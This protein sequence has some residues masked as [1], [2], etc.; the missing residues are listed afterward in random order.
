MQ[1]AARNLL[2]VQ[3]DEDVL[4]HGFSDQKLVLA[5]RAV[6]PENIFGFS[7]SGDLVHPIEHGR[8]AG[9]CVTDPFGRENGGREIFHRRKTSTLTT[10]AGFATL[11]H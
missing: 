4:L 5:V 11:N 9:L 1:I 2:L 8:I 10:N 3:L 6:A 7:Q